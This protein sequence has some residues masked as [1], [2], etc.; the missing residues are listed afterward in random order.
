MQ[1]LQA[2]PSQMVHPQVFLPQSVPR[3]TPITQ[4]TFKTTTKRPRSPSPLPTVPVSI[5]HQGYGYKQPPTLANP[6]Y[7]PSSQSKF[8]LIKQI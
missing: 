5:Y 2:M 4:P 6:N 1:A 7:Q 3:A 8:S